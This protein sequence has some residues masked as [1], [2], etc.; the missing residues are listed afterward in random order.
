[1]HEFIRSIVKNSSHVDKTNRKQH[2]TTTKAGNT[3]KKLF[4]QSA[5]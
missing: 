3:K 5:S 2:N 4:S 1:M